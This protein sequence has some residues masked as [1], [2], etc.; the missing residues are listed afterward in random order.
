M[1]KKCKQ[2]IICEDNSQLKW[3]KALNTPKEIEKKIFDFKFEH[4]KVS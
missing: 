1:M 4:D 2:S 3:S